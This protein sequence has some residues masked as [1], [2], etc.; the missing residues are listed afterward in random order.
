M[1]YLLLIG[2]VDRYYMVSG[3]SAVS[4]GGDLSVGGGD[5]VGGGFGVLDLCRS[6]LDF[7]SEFCFTEDFGNT[8]F[9]REWYRSLMDDSVRRVMFVAPRNSAKTTCCAKKAP[10]WLL[11]RSPDI[12]ILILSRTGAKARS[13]MRFIR[14]NIEGNSRVRAVFPWLEPSGDAPWSDDQIT[15]KNTRMDGE[16]SV[17]AVGLGGSITGFRSDLLI[18]DDLVDRTNV[19][20]DIQ[21]EKVV[22]FWNEIVFPTLNPDGRIFVICT[23][24]SNKDFYSLLMEQEAYRDNIHVVSA[25]RE[26]EDGKPVKDAGGQYISYWPERWPVEK[27]LQIREE[28][29][30]LAFSAQY[31]NNPSGYEGRL[32]KPEWIHHYTVDDDILPKQGNMV[33]VMSVDPNISEEPEADNTAIVTL[34]VDS[35]RGDVYV[36][37]IFARPMGFLNQVEHLKMYAL[38]R[39]L[40]VGK[41]F[42]LGEQTIMKIGVESVA[43]QKALQATGYLMGL[44][45]VEVHHSKMDKVTRLLRMQPHIENGRI[46]F[47]DPTVHSDVR[48]WEPFLE[49]YLSFPRGRRDDMMDALEIAVEI[50]GI[51]G[52]QTGIPWGPGGNLQSRRFTTPG[53]LIYG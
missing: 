40:S 43:Y 20:T 49:E 44:P 3:V 2:K 39:Q 11:G 27:L 8:W 38:R 16:V 29:G 30:S 53:R 26:D 7:F 5:R 34:A 13:N 22:E 9:H 23:R 48:W 51:T 42:L 36:L 1:G 50:A 32:F 14:Q 18:V 52:G 15:V 12:K 33:Y 21:R 37:D 19:N 17:M 24:W 46:K 47:P 4:S 28:I 35:K 25:F 45:V 10:L 6:D 41:T 31:L